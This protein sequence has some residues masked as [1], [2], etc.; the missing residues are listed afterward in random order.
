M[1]KQITEAYKEKE[2]YVLAKEL[3]DGF[4]NQL[5]TALKYS[6]KNFEGAI[7]HTPTDDYKRE[8]NAYYRGKCDA[9]R[10]IAKRLEK[11]HE[12]SGQSL[13]AWLRYENQ[14]K[15]SIDDPELPGNKT[16]KEVKKNWLYFVH[17]TIHKKKNQDVER[18]FPENKLVGKSIYHKISRL[19]GSIADLLEA[20]ACNGFMLGRKY[21][22]DYMRM[23]HDES[24]YFDP[25]KFADLCIE[26][27]VPEEY[28]YFC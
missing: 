13:N 25:Q 7:D 5:T 27:F 3:Y 17:Q 19:K 10:E 20:Y 12:L 15:S 11:E 21:E 16:I 24:E 9:F 1:F 2:A 28:Q 18:I 26:T 6:I 4:F 22:Y 23:P 8:K 14:I